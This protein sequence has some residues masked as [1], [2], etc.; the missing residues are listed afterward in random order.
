[1]NLDGPRNL[2]NEGYNRQEI[3]NISFGINVLNLSN[4]ILS[5]NYHS[6][7]EMLVDQIGNSFIL[8]ERELERKWNL[9]K[10]TFNLEDSENSKAV[11][12]KLYD[13][14]GDRFDAAVSM[15]FLKDQEMLQ[16]NKNYI[17]EAFHEEIEQLR[18]KNVFS[19]KEL[20]Q[21]KNDA[22]DF[23]N[24]NFDKTIERV[25][26]N[27]AGEK[28]LELCDEWNDA[29]NAGNFQE[30]D[31]LYDELYRHYTKKYIYRGEDIAKEAE[32]TL[33]MHKYIE[34][35]VDRDE[36]DRLTDIEQEVF[37]AMFR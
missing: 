14:I 19:D 23:V 8:S 35:K 29:Y 31:H 4:S 21:M 37:N 30:M 16:E 3:N 11:F 10:Y 28:I 20:L 9:D 26:K 34:G 25:L 27:D 6:H 36:G 33:L 17:I 12:S 13:N 32:K 24:K 18:E 1:M 7:G 15:D 22:K 2:I 5:G